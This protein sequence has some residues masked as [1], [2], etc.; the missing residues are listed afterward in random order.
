MSKLKRSISELLGIKKKRPVAYGSL[1]PLPENDDSSFTI[2]GVYDRQQD[3]YED[4]FHEAVLVSL[5]ERTR[6]LEQERNAQTTRAR[7]LE[8]QLRAKEDEIRRT[9]ADRANIEEANIRTSQMETMINDLKKQQGITE[10]QRAAQVAELEQKLQEYRVHCVELES[11]QRQLQERAD[12]LNKEEQALQGPDNPD[13]TLHQDKMRLGERVKSLEALLAHD[14]AL[15]QAGNEA[16]ADLQKSQVVFNK[17]N[18][19]LTEELAS[20]YQKVEDVR[21]DCHRHL[22]QRLEEQQQQHNIEREEAFTVLGSNLT[23]RMV[24]IHKM[25]SEEYQS[26][27]VPDDGPNTTQFLQSGSPAMLRN[28]LLDIQLTADQARLL[29][30]SDATDDLTLRFC[31]LCQRVKFARKPDANPRLGVN[32]FARPSPPCC[33]KYDRTLTFRAALKNL[34]PQ[35]SNESLL[36]AFRLHYQLFFGYRMHSMFH[37]MFAN[38][39]PD[40]TGRIPAFQAG[41]IRNIS[42]DHNG[43]SIRIPL[44]MRFL[45]W[46][47]TPRECSVCTEKLFEVKY[48]SIDEW[49]D[50]CVGFHGEWMWKILQFPVK[51]GQRCNHE[52]DFCTGCLEKHL[53]TQLEQYG[54]S[55]CDQLAC[56]SHGCGRLLTYDEIRLYAKPT[57]FEVYDRYLNLNTLTRYPNFRW[58]LRQGCSSGQLYDEGE[59]NEQLDPHF[60]CEECAFEMCYY[61]SMPWHKGQ[62]CEQ[63]D[64]MRQHG[65]PEFQQ[66]RDWIARN[67]KPCPYCRENIEKGESCFHM[68]CSSCHFEFCWECLADW[69]RIAPHPGVHNDNAHRNGCG[70]RTNELTPTQ[71][72]GTSLQGAMR[73]L[74]R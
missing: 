29:A 25:V 54:R 2:P 71:I 59:D 65:D 57:T 5:R 58:C 42:V 43:S 26:T 34:Q 41:R 17:D 16:Y 45:C 20:V 32:E 11:T 66:T 10:K 60:R 4:N 62:T 73:Q 21:E 53:K 15:R 46:E 23:P 1:D 35:P 48:G 18:S 33:S 44:F 9:R 74:R 56:P 51:L 6:T 61:H 72:S 24:L 12:A 39:K 37:P 40:D 38:T 27:P 30:D 7:H 50:S 68:T 14:R 28:H 3:E 22:I 49:L 36:L 64:S 55:R 13:S 8:V 70:F 19:E 67:T 69:R 52:I 47:K 63:F 31:D